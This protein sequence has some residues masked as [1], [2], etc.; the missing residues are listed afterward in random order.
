MLSTGWLPWTC[1]PNVNDLSHRMVGQCGLFRTGYRVP[2]RDR[3]RLDR[4]G[5]SGRV[6]ENTRARSFGAVAARL[7]RGQHAAQRAR[8][9]VTGPH[10]AEAVRR[11]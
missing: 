7:C 10:K 1:L 4:P 11:S 6:R 9:L 2:P 8:G 3:H 5:R